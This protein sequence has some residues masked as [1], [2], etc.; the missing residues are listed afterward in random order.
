MRV[1][2]VSLP[3]WLAPLLL[4]TIAAITYGTRYWQPQS[5]FWDEN[6]HVASAQ[7]HLDGVMFMEPHPPLGKQLIALGEWLVGDNDGRDTAALLIRDHVSGTQL[8]SGYRFR[9]VRLASVLLS[10]VSVLL[11]Y[12]LLQRITGQRLLAASFAV[13]LALDNALVVHARAAMLEGIQLCFVLLS[14]WLFTASVTRGSAIR[15][16]DYLRLGAAIGLA[17]AVKLNAAVLL[18][19]MPALY[20]VDQW[21]ALRERRWRRTAGDIGDGRRRAGFVLPAHRQRDRG[22]ARTAVQGFTGIPG[23]PAGRLHVDAGRFRGRP[24]RPSALHQGI[25]GRRAAARCLQAG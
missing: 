12:A 11:A 16:H 25:R 17:I 24:R 4:L 1:S 9:G 3:R 8:P 5:L 10:I 7:K 14:L 23:A 2:L 20:F 22:Q 6:Y 18:L 19:L 13:L 15:L 21:P